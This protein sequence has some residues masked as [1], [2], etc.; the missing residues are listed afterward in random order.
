M[1]NPKT[2]ESELIELKNLQEKEEYDKLIVRAQVIKFSEPAKVGKGLTKQEV[3]IADSTEAAFLTLWENNVHKL[4]LGKS[5]QFNRITVRTY[6]GKHQL[7]F[8]A[9]GASIE[10]IEDLG[11]VMEDSYDLHYD[12][13]LEE[14][15]IVGVSQRSTRVQCKKGTVKK[16]SENQEIATTWHY[17][18]SMY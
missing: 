5:Y 18:A 17:P 16:T 12:N 15:Q 6:R 2:L 3:T 9:S 10:D 1:Q 11:E 8:P 4:C 13:L 7:S 14:A